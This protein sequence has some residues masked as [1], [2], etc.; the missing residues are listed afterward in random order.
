MCPFDPQDRH[1]ASNTQAHFQ[2]LSYLTKYTHDSIFSLCVFRHF[3]FLLIRSWDELE[4]E[5]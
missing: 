2:Y 5:M 4:G 1:I 3:C